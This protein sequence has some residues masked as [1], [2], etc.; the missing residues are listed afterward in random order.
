MKKVGTEN[1][2]FPTVL[3]LCL[4]QWAH[5]VKPMEERQEKSASLQ[6]IQ[7]RNQLSEIGV[8]AT[9]LVALK[10]CLTNL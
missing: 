7:L 5:P 9:S 8:V 1:G 6:N 10:E 4:I 3:E 2:S